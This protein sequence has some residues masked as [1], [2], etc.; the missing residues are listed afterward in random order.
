[1]KGC[2]RS[3]TA[4]NLYRAC[5]LV[6]K[7]AAQKKKDESNDNRPAGEKEQVREKTVLHAP[8]RVV[9]LEA[10]CNEVLCELGEFPRVG[11]CGCVA[12]GDHLHGS[13]LI[14]LRVGRQA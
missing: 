3:S 9:L 2:V 8:L 1:M 5:Q 10:L 4:V 11:K 12:H 6:S 7:S 14:H 13:L